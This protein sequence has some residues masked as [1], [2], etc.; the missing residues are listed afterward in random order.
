[1]HGAVAFASCSHCEISSFW[2]LTSEANLAE[3]PLSAN[4]G[5]AVDKR[6]HHT[7]QLQRM[8]CSKPIH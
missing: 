5:P 4:G 6:N 1:M 8:D 2:W 7:M 3:L